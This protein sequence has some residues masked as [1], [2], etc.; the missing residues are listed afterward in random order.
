VKKKLLFIGAPGSGKGTHAKVMVDKYNYLHLATGDILRQA[1]KDQTEVGKQAKTYIEKG[2]LVPD[3]V[4]NE[5]VAE[6]LSG[7]D[8]NQG[9]ILDGFPRTKVQ[10][11]FLANRGI[12]FD[13]V[14]YMKV[15]LDLVIERMA[16]RLTCT[17]CGSSFHKTNR[18]PKVD[19][20]CDNC[21]KELVIRPD[22]N[23]ET[24]KDRYNTY[25][26][27]TLPVIDMY[28]DVLVEVDAAGTVDEVQEEIL[29]AI[30]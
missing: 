5:I 16:G 3:S 24:V 13:A 19:M 14:I 10:A 2:E 25:L 8:S 1:I 20:I 11:E 15:E 12:K 22:D 29:D 28:Q 9:F 26:K 21:S 7:L 6:K 27:Q 30:K 18:A 23:P 4:V 17:N